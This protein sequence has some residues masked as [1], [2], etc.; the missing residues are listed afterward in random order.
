MGLQNGKNPK[1]TGIDVSPCY[2]AIRSQISWEV[3][4]RSIAQIFP[5]KLPN[6]GKP[7][8]QRYLQH[9]IADF[10]FYCAMTDHAPGMAA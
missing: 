8:S 3:T 6:Q 10:S 9:K 5:E 4:E 2:S 1:N 7:L